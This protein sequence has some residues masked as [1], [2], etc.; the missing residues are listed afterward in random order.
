[1]PK[2]RLTENH[3]IIKRFQ[4]LCDKADDLGLTIDYRGQPTVIDN[5]SGETYYLEDIEP[6][7]LFSEF[8]PKTE[9]KLTFKK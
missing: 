2:Y 1:M 6:D 7:H 5:D 9:Y 8:P 4:E 3:P